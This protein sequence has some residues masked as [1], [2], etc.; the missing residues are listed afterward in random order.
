MR[1]LSDYDQ[2][3]KL[4]TWISS[5]AQESYQLCCICTNVSSAKQTSSQVEG[6]H[7]VHLQLQ[8]TQS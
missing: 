6:D 1:H 2:R 7:I 3:E 5:R 4:P 8:G